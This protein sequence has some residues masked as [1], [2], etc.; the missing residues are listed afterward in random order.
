MIKKIDE[1]DAIPWFKHKGNGGWIGRTIRIGHSQDHF[2]LS[3]EGQSLTYVS[4][5]NTDNNFVIDVP[6]GGWII[7][8]YCLPGDRV[9]LL[10]TDGYLLLYSYSPDTKQSELLNQYQIKLNEAREEE[11]V[12]LTI[13]KN[14][15]L[16][17]I[18]TRTLKGENRYPTSRIILFKLYGE[19]IVMLD[20][21]D[22][23]DNEGN[24]YFAAMKF[25]K[26]SLDIQ[27]LVALN[28]VAPCYV[29]SFIFDGKKLEEFKKYRTKVE[30]DGI[31]NLVEFGDGFATVDRYTKMIKISYT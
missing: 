26:F 1:G 19:D 5:E 28:S 3:K 13:C 16:I 20:E 31:R 10:T 23:S 9:L 22:L 2:I 25:Y 7:D 8:T 27:I 4:V 6:L 15:E 24:S 12:T 29:Y 30:V 17:A 18:A 11:S 21:I 14:F